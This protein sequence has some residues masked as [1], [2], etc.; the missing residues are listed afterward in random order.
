MTRDLGFDVTSGLDVVRDHKADLMAIGASG[1]WSW[2]AASR[3]GVDLTADQSRITKVFDRM[4]QRSPMAVSALAG[5]RGPKPFR[6]FPTGADYTENNPTQ[7]NTFLVGPTVAGLTGWCVATVYTKSDFS[8]QGD[9]LWGMGNG[10]AAL[11]LFSNSFRVYGVQAD[12]IAG[13]PGAPAGQFSWVI[14]NWDPVTANITVRTPSA[15]V[16]A[17]V[18]AYTGLPTQLNMGVGRDALNGNTICRSFIHDLMFKN[19]AL[20]AAEIDAL[21]AVLFNLYGI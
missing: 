2:Y 11:S 9:C 5:T 12:F 10:G 17:P 20:S 15:E 7:T 19:S 13:P 1:V 8:G 18:A 4:G 6:G 16:V 3:R 14:A 21:Q